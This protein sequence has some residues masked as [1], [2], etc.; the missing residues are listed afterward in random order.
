MAMLKRGTVLLLVG[1]IALGGGVLLIESQRGESQ[2]SDDSDSA[3]QGEGEQL[4]PFAEEEVERLTIER[5]EGK[6]AFSKSADGTWQ[7][8]A[9][10]AA[11]AEGGAIAFLLTQLTSPSAHTLSVDPSTLA[12]FGLADP[13]VTVKLTANGAPYE[14][15]LGN[16]DFTGSQRYVETLDT[17]AQGAE[18]NNSTEAEQ[19]AAV[20]IHVV[21][22]NFN[23]AVNR[24]TPEWLAPDDA[25]ANSPTDSSGTE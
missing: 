12:D 10:T 15:R 5:P 17:P 21:S 20:K 1:A 4:F 9:P 3:S 11:P 19:A 22:S 16:A 6:I 18:Q 14:L 24:P 23:S 2:V 7:M 8:T 25:A 13:S